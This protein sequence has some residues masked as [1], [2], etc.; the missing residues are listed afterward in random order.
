M[1]SFKIYNTPEKKVVSFKPLKKGT[2][3]IYA[4][5][6]TVYNKPTIANLR[7][8]INVDILNRWLSYSGY[9]VKLV[10]NITDIEDKIIKA[11][12]DEGLNAEDKSAIKKYTTVFEDSFFD[13]LNKLNIKR[14]SAY[15]HATDRDVIQEM[16]KIISALIKKGVAYVSEDGVYFAI[17][18]YKNYGKLANLDKKG[19]KKGVRVNLDE[20]DKENARDFALW[21]F[22]KEGEP[23]WPA[24]FG[25]G[26]PGW[27]I[28]CSAMAHKYL[29]ERIDIHA[30]GVDL[31]F[32]H[33]ENEIAQTE[34]FTGKE[35]SSY[36]FHPEHMMINGERMG[37]SLKNYYLLEN[38]KE[39]FGV[40]PLALRMLALMSHYR[41]KLNFTDTSIKDA[42]KALDG[43]R[44]FVAK[45]ETKKSLTVKKN[46]Y[47]ELVSKTKKE[48]AEALNNDL[49]M[50]MAMASVFELVKKVNKRMTETG[51]KQTGP[52]YRFMMEIDKVLGL[53]LS[54]KQILEIPKQVQE[55]SKKREE[56]REKSNFKMSDKLRK[57]I[58][59]LG[60]G[61]EDTPE[62]PVLKKL[63]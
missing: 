48:F 59:D 27:H 62:G 54:K 32:P 44:D 18:K 14:A 38:L 33:H 13:A 4:C 41:E 3:K 31:V 37:K 8:Y 55:L 50:P 17:D 12:K 2:V 11:V 49:S 45:L 21:K 36:W 20:Y 60:Y 5:G 35:F 34:A 1:N 23:S 51:T 39:K 58:E 9:K 10:E 15:P 16:I 24:P 6:P 40:E 46:V 57:K 25:E 52:V 63:S 42:Q 7:T 29:G 19:L 53:D 26:R 22:K 47:I 30:G 43:L 28:E 56:Y 61:V